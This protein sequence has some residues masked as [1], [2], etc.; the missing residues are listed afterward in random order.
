MKRYKNPIV[1]VSENRKLIFNDYGDRMLIEPATRGSYG[2]SQ[3][4]D[5]PV[6]PAAKH[7]APQPPPPPKPPTARELLRQRLGLDTIAKPK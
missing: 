5:L 2:F 1:T 3:I 4:K 7:R 6:R